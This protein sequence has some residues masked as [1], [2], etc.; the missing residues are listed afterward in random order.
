MV[1]SKVVEAEILT[2]FN[3]KKNVN[4]IISLCNQVIMN[5]TADEQ[6]I[7]RAKL[8]KADV[9][10]KHNALQLIKEVKAVPD[11]PSYLAEKARLVEEDIKKRAK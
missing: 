3:A 6:L 7:L 9:S 4:K 1:K 10:K 11:L 8:D 2:R 5:K